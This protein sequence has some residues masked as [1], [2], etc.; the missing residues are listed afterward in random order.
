MHDP[1][2][3]ALIRTRRLE[4]SYSQEG[5]CRGICAVSYLSKIEHGV[6]TPSDEILQKLFAALDLTYTTDE[7]TLSALRADIDACFA[8]FWEDRDAPDARARL[9]AAHDVLS[10]SPLHL[11]GLLFDALQA[12][13]QGD[14]AAACALLDRL[15]SQQAQLD[16]D[17]LVRLHLLTGLCASEDASALSAFSRAETLTPSPITAHFLALAH[18]LHGRYHD[19]LRFAAQAYA[20]AAQAGNVFF[21]TQA[22]FLEGA[23]YSNLY[24]YALMQAAFDRVR[25]LAPGNA[26]LLRAVDYNL[27][28]SYVA[29]GDAAQA[30]PYLLRACSEDTAPE[31]RFFTLHKLAL[32]Y[33]LLGRTEEG[34]QT[35]AQAQT[36]LDTNADLPA[37]YHDLLRLIRLRFTPGYARTEEYLGL[38][39][40]LYRDTDTQIHHGFS[41]FHAPLLLE[42][43]CA[44]RLYKE[45]LAVAL[46]AR[47]PFP[48]SLQKSLLST[49]KKD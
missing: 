5:L 36:V 27:G 35:L 47:C 6:V 21:M 19:A 17:N 38:A 42:A 12:Y 23:C 20:R 43:L 44:H 16:T 3:G 49:D 31:S 10:C 26:S 33:Q 24:E 46:Q 4:R 30:L 13:M 29:V 9:Q 48:D 34:L 14:I 1:Y 40:M 37:L 11:S 32:T 22:A 18:Y 2:V 45:A 41:L 15:S 7:A 39:R 28:A 8:A 25:A